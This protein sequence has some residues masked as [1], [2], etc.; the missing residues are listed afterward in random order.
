MRQENIIRYWHAVELLQPQAAPKIE[1]RDKPY[2]SFF[3][4]TYIGEPIP[5]WSADSPAFEQPIPKRRV[6]S[7]TLFAHLY[8]SKDVAEQL[9]LL[10]GADQGY[11]DEPKRRESALF[12]LK[13]TAEGLMVQDSLVLSS[14]A[15]F[16][17]RALTGQDWTRGFRYRPRC[18][19]S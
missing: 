7:H 14:E 18:F 9:Q 15:W 4:D 13:F 10:Y 2:D 8:D 19:A 11:K 6:W 12:A 1:K 3:Y 5:P 16:L 17:G